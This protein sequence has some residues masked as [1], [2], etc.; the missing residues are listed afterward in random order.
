MG[1]RSRMNFKIVS[2]RWGWLS[3][4]SDSRLD[5]YGRMSAKSIANDTKFINAKTL[6]VET[7]GRIS[8]HIKAA[9]EFKRRNGNFPTWFDASAREE[10]IEG[11]R[12]L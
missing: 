12:S 4:L 9:D 2:K 11:K 5:Q 10:S 7:Q 6:P 8:L 1:G 3:E